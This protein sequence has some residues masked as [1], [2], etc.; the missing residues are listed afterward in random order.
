MTWRR[1]MYVAVLVGIATL[2]G[3]KWRDFVVVWRE[4]LDT[5]IALTI[6]MS[7]GVTVQ[8]RNFLAFLPKD[9]ARPRF[10]SMIRVWALGSL[11]NYL[12][13]SQTGVAVRT[14]LLRRMGISV[15]E[16]VIASLRQAA[17]SVWMSLFV[18]G[19]SLLWLDWWSYY[20][21]GLCLLTVF[22]VTPLT[23]PAVR[24][25]IA[26]LRSK[27][28]LAVL[29]HLETAVAAI[30]YRSAAAVAAQYGCGALVLFVGYTRFG[31]DIDLAAAA[32][33]ACAVYVSSIVAVLPGNLGL[34]EAVY[35]GFGKI[36]GLSVDESL[37]LAF[38]FRAANL[39]GTL[40]LAALPTKSTGGASSGTPVDGQ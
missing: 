20:I 40:L 1:V 28:K 33:L 34:L 35:A 15:V 11:A 32:I 10:I 29:E 5:F 8:A 6:I 13:P 39:T 37:A 16:S 3:A 21:P 25:L 24:P 31:V 38:L 18:A 22:A 26:R 14:F 36:N 30:P 23:L 2:I 9:C 4:H 19:A 7:A 17:T 27:R 12:G